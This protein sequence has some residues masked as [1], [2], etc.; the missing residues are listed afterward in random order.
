MLKTN[1]IR[2]NINLF[3]IKL[4]DKKL[5]IRNIKSEQKNLL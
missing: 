5:L 2:N 4:S 3:D 1:G